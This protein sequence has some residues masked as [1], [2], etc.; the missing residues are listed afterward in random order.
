MFHTSRKGQ[1]E[2]KIPR[3]GMAK[4]VTSLT[5]GTGQAIAGESLTKNLTIDERN[6][7]S[8]RTCQ[9]KRV[10]FEELF[11][12]TTDGSAAAMSL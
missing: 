12:S 6:T 3:E 8:G 7:P 5:P 2:Q 10:H 11:D 1:E 4:E 9:V